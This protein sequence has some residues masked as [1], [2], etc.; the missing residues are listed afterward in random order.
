MFNRVALMD[1]LEP[2]VTEPK[3]LAETDQ[4]KAGLKKIME[5]HFPIEEWRPW[6]RVL[7]HGDDC[8]I[9][10]LLCQ[11]YGVSEIAKKVFKKP[12]SVSNDLKR[13]RKYCSKKNILIPDPDQ[14]RKI[15]EL[16]KQLSQVSR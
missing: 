16:R 4:F 12:I 5:I 10:R 3:D 15:K 7:D 13:L 14:H 9:I 8:T 2:Q 11:G 1:A 6:E